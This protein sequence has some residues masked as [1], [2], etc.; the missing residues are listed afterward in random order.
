M[1]WSM[2]GPVAGAPELVSPVHSDAIPA[3][4]D[5]CAALLLSP[6]STMTLLC[7]GASGAR[8]LRNLNPVVAIGEPPGSG[9]TTSLPAA[10]VAPQ[11][12]RTHPQGVNSKTR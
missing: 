2:L 6:S 11:R 9:G 1:T 8:V 5:P 12:G 10:S 3:S 7:T 4:C